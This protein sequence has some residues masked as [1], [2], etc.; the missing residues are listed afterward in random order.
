MDAQPAAGGGGFIDLRSSPVPE[1]SPVS[2]EAPA[3]ADPAPRDALAIEPAATAES[4]EDLSASS[5]SLGRMALESERERKRE[6]QK[7]E[8]FERKSKQWYLGE[9]C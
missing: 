2:A 3:Q 1:A 9:P 5:T 4:G 7:W 6:L 8:F